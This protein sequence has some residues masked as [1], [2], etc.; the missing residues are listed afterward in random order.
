MQP[1]KA[2]HLTFPNHHRRWMGTSKGRL[3]AYPRHLPRVDH[4]QGPLS[5]ALITSSDWDG[6]H[7][8]SHEMAAGII[9]YLGQGQHTDSFLGGW[10]NLPWKQTQIHVHGQSGVFKNSLVCSDLHQ[11]AAWWKTIPWT[12]GGP[13]RGSS[14]TVSWQVSWVILGPDVPLSGWE[15]PIYLENV[16][17]LCKLWCKAP[18]P[19]A[20]PIHRLSTEDGL[21]AGK[22]AFPKKKPS[23]P[24]VFLLFFFFLII[25]LSW[26][27]HFLK[28]ILPYH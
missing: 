27:T 11:S 6:S 8:K 22:S 15:G 19:A 21:L 12:V 10:R 20:P 3:L 7:P 16:N 13:A 9:D 14:W 26:T 1:V 28:K 5:I 18:V 25:I 23:Q 17:G 2:N 24:I 4:F